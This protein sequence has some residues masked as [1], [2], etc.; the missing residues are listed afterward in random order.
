VI[1]KLPT[2]LGEVTIPDSFSP[3]GLSHAVECPLR[4]VL[5]SREVPAP[6]LPTHPAAERGSVFHTLLERAGKGLVPRIGSAHDS[7]EADFKQLLSKACS[8]LAMSPD[9]AHFAELR[10]TLSEVEWHN[11]TKE[12]ILAAESLLVAAPAVARPSQRSH[13]RPRDY[14]DLLDE[15]TFHEV[16]ITSE[17]LRLKGRI[18]LL[19]IGVPKKVRI[20]DYKT[21]RVLDRQGGILTHIALQLRLYALAIS[22]VDPLAEVELCVIAGASSYPLAWDANT[23]ADTERLLE[24]LLDALPSGKKREAADLARPGPWCTTCPHRHVC[25]GYLDK[26]PGAWANGCDSGPYPFD[27]WG[28][29]RGREQSAA[30][31]SL[32]ITDAANRNVRVQRIDPRHG[33][34]ESYVPGRRLYIFGLATTQHSHHQG[35]HF[36][37]RNF[38][39]LPSDRSPVRAWSL[40]VY[41]E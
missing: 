5:S 16:E 27:I 34:V 4:I 33:S 24:G 37:P 9:T 32:D 23:R 25:R 10:S 15:G 17:D 31:L 26:T 6:R 38:F 12:L 3:S 2:P 35:K 40:A 39:E 41:E 13:T 1:P 7:I 21:G 36:H 20:S 29:L 22:Q 28:E 14:T 11:K 8:R 30:G 19:E 18:D